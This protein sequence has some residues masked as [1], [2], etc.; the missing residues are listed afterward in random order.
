MLERP[1][2]SKESS[3]TTAMIGSVMSAE[4]TQFGLSDGENISVVDFTS[5][6]S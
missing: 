6:D 2:V 1:Y 4:L 3:P 5:K